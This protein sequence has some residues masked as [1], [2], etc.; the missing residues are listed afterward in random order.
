MQ[1]VGAGTFSPYLHTARLQE[2][3]ESRN[4]K[5]KEKSNPDMWAEFCA[6]KV[7]FFFLF[8][9]P[10]VCFVAFQ[11]FFWQLVT[12]G[13]VCSWQHG[14]RLCGLIYAKCP[15]STQTQSLCPQ[16][17]VQTILCIMKEA[18]SRTT[19]PNLVFIHPV[20]IKASGR[21]PALLKVRKTW[22]DAQL[23][24]C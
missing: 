17:D 18:A 8:F 9:S 11:I 21:S 2:S 19:M 7:L 14:S 4:R 22:I 1:N 10:L 6:L 5:R 23:L 20:S 16:M 15:R 3:G 12:R 24:S 13:A